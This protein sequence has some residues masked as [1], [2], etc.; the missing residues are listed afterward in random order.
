MNPAIIIIISAIV[1]VCISKIVAEHYLRVT[2]DMID[3]MIKESEE[4]IKEC[5]HS[6]EETLDRKLR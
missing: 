4:K 1:S 6:I 5:A 2:L 3:K